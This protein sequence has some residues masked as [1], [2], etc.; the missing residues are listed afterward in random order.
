MWRIDPAA[1]HVECGSS[2]S[3]GVFANGFTSIVDITFDN[4][5]GL[6]VV[7]IDENSWITVEGLGTPAGGTVNRCRPSGLRCIPIATGLPIPTSVALQRGHI[8]ATINALIPGEATVT[9]I[10]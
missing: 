10:V 3:C 9:R 2:P 8:Y 1:R 7:E 5:G 6:Y 4:D